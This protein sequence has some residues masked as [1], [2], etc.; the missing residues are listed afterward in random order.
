MRV[1]VNCKNEL[2]EDAMFC[3]RCGTKLADDENNESNEMKFC[4][5]CGAELVDDVCPRCTQQKTME[6][7]QKRDKQFSKF[8]MDSNEKLVTVLGNNYVENYFQG[9]IKKGFAVVSDK[10]VYFQGTTFELRNKAN[11][12]KKIIKMK[13]SRTID[14]IDVTGTGFDSY[15]NF[16]LCILNKLLLLP[17]GFCG[18]LIIMFLIMGVGGGV[19]F[20]KGMLYPFSFISLQVTWN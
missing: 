19:G 9:N 6:D 16:G 5:K 20:L 3:D 10:R 12:N 15:S 7:S 4:E 13:Q 1:C 14:L 18:F 17:V 11:G 8:F 2:P